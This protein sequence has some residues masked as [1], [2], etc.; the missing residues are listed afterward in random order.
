VEGLYF[1][2][3][4]AV[5]VAT[6]GA[7]TDWRTGLIPNWITYPAL[8]LGPLIHFI[9]FGVNDG[10][11]LGLLPS[12]VGML[13][14]GLV[15]YVIFKIAVKNEEGKEEEKAMG[16]GDVK[17]LAAVGGFLGPIDGIAAEFYA[18]LLGALFALAV[19]AW[20][21]KLLATLLNSLFLLLNPILPKRYRRKMSSENMSKMRLGP[22]IVPGILVALF[23]EY[24]PYLWRLL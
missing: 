9:S 1:L 17:L 12:L 10:L 16:G 15:P 8:A 7:I 19:L 23:L 5:L 4:A 11:E 18:F 2:Q 20:R 3:A 13:I 6:I 22:A 14:C 21:G 24:E